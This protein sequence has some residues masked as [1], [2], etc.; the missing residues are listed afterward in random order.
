MLL[1]IPH[2]L[3]SSGHICPSRCVTGCPSVRR[4]VG[5]ATD[6]PSSQ[7]GVAGTRLALAAARTAEWR[8]LRN[9]SSNFKG[10]PSTLYAWVMKYDE[11]LKRKK[12]IQKNM[13]EIIIRIWI[14]FHQDMMIKC[15]PHSVIGAGEWKMVVPWFQ[16][17]ILNILIRWSQICLLWFYPIT[18]DPQGFLGVFHIQSVRRNGISC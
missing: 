2:D 16:R 13:L 3:G 1:G 5:S 10:F 8:G 4:G 17:P 15:S 12:N 18:S 7:R 14:I 11:T 9:S 6:M